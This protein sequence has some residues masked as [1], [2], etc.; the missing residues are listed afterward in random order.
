MFSGTC[1]YSSAVAEPGAGCSCLPPGAMQRWFP[2]RTF[3]EPPPGPAAHRKLTTATSAIFQ[4]LE[5]PPRPQLVIGPALLNTRT[6]TLPSS[7]PGAGNAAPRPPGLCVGASWN[8]I[9]GGTGGTGDRTDTCW[10]RVTQCLW[11]TTKPTAAGSA[12][13]SRCPTGSEPRPRSA[14]CR[15]ALGTMGCSQAAIEKTHFLIFPPRTFPFSS[16]LF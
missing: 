4:L 8:R 14:S 10:L 5:K 2:H 15:G 12:P 13:C 6:Q 9:A 3:M 1:A 7:H 16:T 11:K